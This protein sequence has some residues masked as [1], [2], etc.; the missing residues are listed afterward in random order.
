MSRSD[1]AGF[2]AAP[3]ALNNTLKIN[4]STPLR[5]R[6][7]TDG[8][9]GLLCLAFVFK[10][11]ATTVLVFACFSSIA[12][13]PQDSSPS[14]EKVEPP[15][16][17]A[18]HSINPVRLLVRGKNLNGARVRSNNVSLQTSEVFVNR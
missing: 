5:A 13:F 6:L 18:R 2:C 10:L 7:L 3:S 4:L 1:L 16:W 12:A 11:I 14:V 8:P 15:S 17:W 9:A